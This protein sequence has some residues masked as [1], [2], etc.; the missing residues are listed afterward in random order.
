M[1]VITPRRPGLSTVNWAHPLARGLVF[2]YIPGAAFDSRPRVAQSTETNGTAPTVR[3]IGLRTAAAGRIAIAP[4]S[5][6]QIMYRSAAGYSIVAFYRSNSTAGYRF[7]GSL[8]KDAWSPTSSGSARAWQF[9]IDNASD[10]VRFIPF[11]DS[12]SIAQA[13]AAGVGSNQINCA[14]AVMDWRATTSN[15]WVVVNGVQGTKQSLGAGNAN[16]IDSNILV[17]NDNASSDFSVEAVY[18]FKRVLSVEESRIFNSDPNVLLRGV[19]RI[20]ARNSVAGAASTVGRLVNRG[21]FAGGLV[22]GRL[23]A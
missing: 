11:N 18:G 10:T 17:G 3:G 4:S 1:S 19:R 23:S 15:V 6:G 21:L 9:R 5:V 8:D 16:N 7:I 22:G 12:V 20:G 14:V 13:T 2:A